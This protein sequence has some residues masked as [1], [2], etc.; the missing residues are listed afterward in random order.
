MV[1]AVG[2]TLTDPVAPNVPSPFRVTEVVL[3][4]L[5]CS[6]EDDPL[7]IVPGWALSVIE[8]LCA[9]G[10]GT[11]DGDAEYA[12]PPQ[13]K[14]APSSRHKNTIRSRMDTVTGNS[15]KGT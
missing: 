14:A 4:E 1:V 10:E 2:V 13:P 12:A 15:F 9:L 11:G 7:P 8:G 3:L 6:T 5:H